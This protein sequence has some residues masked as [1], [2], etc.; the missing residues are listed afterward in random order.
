[1]VSWI[2]TSRKWDLK[3]KQ[4]SILEGWTNLHETHTG[5]NQYMSK[6]QQ[7]LVMLSEIEISLQLFKYFSRAQDWVL[8]IFH[9]CS[10]INISQYI[11][12]SLLS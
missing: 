7:T 6:N 12:I 1:M 4:A 10:T 3:I 5:N 9:N 11:Y 8:Y 2:H